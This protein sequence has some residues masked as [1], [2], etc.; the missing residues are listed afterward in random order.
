MKSPIIEVSRGEWG[1]NW[2]LIAYGQSFYLGQDSKFCHRVLNEHPSNVQEAIGTADLSKDSSKRKLA[3]YILSSL[4]LNKESLKD[5]ESWELC[6][7]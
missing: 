6:C 5:I 1:Y 7:Q 3:N 4:G 2:T